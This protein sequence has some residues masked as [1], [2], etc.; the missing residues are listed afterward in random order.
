[1]KL[2]NLD[3][4]IYPFF[5]N[6]KIPINIQNYLYNLLEKNTIISDKY[7]LKF[8]WF[9]THDIIKNLLLLDKEFITVLIELESSSR[10]RKII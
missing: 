9:C 8:L 5:I 3:I 1:M 4:F 2:W 10:K 7:F 6:F